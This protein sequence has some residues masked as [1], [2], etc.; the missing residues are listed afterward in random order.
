MKIRSKIADIQPDWVCHDC[1]Q[2]WGAWWEGPVY[3]GPS[4]HCA[5]FHEGN[6]NVCGEVKVV[7]EARDFGYL[8]QG[9]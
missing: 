3:T 7:T 4:P 6:C 1:G 5:T 9:W 2:K 8:R